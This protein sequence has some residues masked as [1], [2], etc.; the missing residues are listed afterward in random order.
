LRNL[1]NLSKQAVLVQ[2]PFVRAV[3]VLAQRL[4]TT[5]AAAA[6]AA[7]AAI[8]AVGLV[9]HSKDRLTA[10]AETVTFIVTFVEKQDET[11]H[12]NLARIVFI[13]L[14]VLTIGKLTKRVGIF[15]QV[16]KENMETNIFELY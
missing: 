5:M 6:A 15:A 3:L 8:T 9:R 13:A 14:A 12:F 16:A 4:V 11:P 1:E 2:I 7:A 10:P